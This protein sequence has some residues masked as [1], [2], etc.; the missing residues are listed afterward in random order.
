MEPRWF[1]GT[2]DQEGRTYLGGTNAFDLWFDETLDVRVT[3]GASANDWD[4]FYWSR[5]R[6]T[7]EWGTDDMRHADHDKVLVEALTY[8]R[9]FAPWV[10]EEMT[11]GTKEYHRE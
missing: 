2:W 5:A 9:I 8:L 7:Y 10:E 1:K 3:M 11:K 4:W 6:Q